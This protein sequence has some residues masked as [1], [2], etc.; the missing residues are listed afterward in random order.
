MELLT[1]AVRSIRFVGTHRS[2][3][4]GSV[5]CSVALSAA[6]KEAAADLPQT[7]VIRYRLENCLP[8][9]VTD[10]SRSH[11]NGFAARDYIPGTAVRGMVLN[12]LAQ[13]EPEWFEA[14]KGALLTEACFLDAVPCPADWEP[15]P[16]LMG[17]Y[18][19]KG[20]ETVTSVLLEDVA[21]KKVLDM[22][23]GTGILAILAA[24]MGAA[25]PVDAIDIDDIAAESAMEN[26]SLNG[27][28]DRLSVECGDASSLAG[29]SGYDLIL[30]NINRNILMA[31]MPAYV[32][33]MAPGGVLLVSGFYVEDVPMLA[34]V[35][36]K[37]SLQ[38]VSEQSRDDWAVVKFMKK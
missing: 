35:A 36:E 17:F 5:R 14:H 18:G 11:A 22:G 27:V 1:Q 7:A 37:C 8:V 15:L 10:L 34:A 28:G 9:V 25:S 32:K 2:R 38:Y 29:R 31:D 4:L 23:C 3:G 26:A 19:E 13:Q 33:T 30:A 24:K 20:K 16:P 12:A 21:G 6:R